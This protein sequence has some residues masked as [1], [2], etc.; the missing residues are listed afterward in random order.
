MVAKELN[1]VISSQIKFADLPLS[2]KMYIGLA[3]HGACVGIGMVLLCG[4]LV[5]GLDKIVE[6][7]F[8]VYFICI[9]AICMALVP[10]MKRYLK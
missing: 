9:P 3:C 10:F 1:E 8:F 4:L 6:G 7:V 2:R 5:Y